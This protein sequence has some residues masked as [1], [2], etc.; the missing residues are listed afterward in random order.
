MN[1][2]DLPS[3]RSAFTCYA[4]PFVRPGNAPRD[5]VGSASHEL[6]LFVGSPGDV[7][8]ERDAVDEVA[9]QLNLESLYGFRLLVRNIHVEHTIAEL[10]DRV[11]K[12]LSK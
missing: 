6:R 12:L 3:R 11:R 8:E 10:A 5:S 9:T 7:Q 1:G 2:R 4:D